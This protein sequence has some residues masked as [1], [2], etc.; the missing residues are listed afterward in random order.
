MVLCAYLLHRSI[1]LGEE[2]KERD[3]R[4]NI[5]LQL[6][7]HGEREGERGGEGGGEG[8]GGEGAGR[9]RGVA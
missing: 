7:L 8:G 9:R 3:L 6:I 2:I 1:E 5:P 4:N